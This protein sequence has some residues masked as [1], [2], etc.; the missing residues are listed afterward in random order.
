MTPYDTC[1]VVEWLRL[2]ALNAGGPGW[3]P[4]LGNKICRITTKILHAATKTQY[5]QINT[6]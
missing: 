5:S 1:L 6:Y 2:H 3:I 4:G